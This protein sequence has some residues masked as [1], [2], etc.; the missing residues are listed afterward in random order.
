MLTIEIVHPVVPYVRRTHQGRFSERAKSYHANQQAIKD[1]LNFWKRD[2]GYSMDEPIWGKDAMLAFGCTFFVKKRVT[3]K[4]LSNLEKAIEDA[5]QG[6]VL[7]PDDR[8]IWRRL[9]GAKVQA[10]EDQ[11]NLTVGEA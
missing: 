1:L 2:N 11:F 5:C 4:D 6:G 3:V 8:Q 10:D 9:P 7:F